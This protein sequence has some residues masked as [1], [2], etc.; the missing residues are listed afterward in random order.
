MLETW[1][2]SKLRVVNIS[3]AARWITLILHFYIQAFFNHA[4]WKSLH[5]VFTEYMRHKIYFL[6]YALYGKSCISC[7]ILA[8]VYNHEAPQCTLF[9]VQIR[10]GLR[11]SKYPRILFN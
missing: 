3:L 1:S 4:S 6:T 11:I 8:Y 2:Y 7:D 10:R 5:S 9:C